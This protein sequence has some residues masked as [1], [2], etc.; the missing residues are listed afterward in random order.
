MIQVNKL[1][2]EFSEFVAW[3]RRF[4]VKEITF[5]IGCS[6]SDQQK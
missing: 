1:N 4:V 5:L 2:P 6:C 3:K